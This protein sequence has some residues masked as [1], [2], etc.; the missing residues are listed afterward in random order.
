MKKQ[1]EKKKKVIQSS[2]FQS[3]ICSGQHNLSC[4][5]YIYIYIYNIQKQTVEL[6]R[7]EKRRKKEVGRRK[8]GDSNYREGRFEKSITYKKDSKK[9]NEEKEKEEQRRKRPAA[10][11]KKKRRRQKKSQKKKKT[12]R[13]NSKKM[14]TWLH[15]I[16]SFDVQFL[17]PQFLLP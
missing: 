15:K 7:W 5:K 16:W 4:K 6:Q 10:M 11:K 13:R 8:N 2:G 9:S 12:K 1:K 17:L 14:H 3:L